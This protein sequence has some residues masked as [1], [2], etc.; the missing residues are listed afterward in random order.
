MNEFNAS[1]K[2]LMDVGEGPTQSSTGSECR[3]VTIVTIVIC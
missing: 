3:R 2:T 1:V